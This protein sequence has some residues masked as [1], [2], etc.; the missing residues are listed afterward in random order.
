MRLVLI[1]FQKERDYILYLNNFFT[2]LPLA[3]A[4]KKYNINMTGTTRKNSKGIP[5]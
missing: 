1:L 5:Q 3:K 2:S 4:R